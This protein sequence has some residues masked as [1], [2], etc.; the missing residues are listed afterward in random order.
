MLWIVVGAGIDVPASVPW[1]MR[2]WLSLSGLVGHEFLSWYAVLAL[3]V[4]ALWQFG[5]MR[6]RWARPFASAVLATTTIAFA[7]GG[8]HVCVPSRCEYLDVTSAHIGVDLVYGW[9][10]I[11]E[12]ARGTTVAYT[13]INLPYPLTGDRLANRVIYANIDGRPNW[14]FHDYDRAYRAGRFTPA[15]P[16][17]ATGSGELLPARDTAPGNAPARPRYERMEGFRDGW[18]NNLKSLHVGYLFIAALSAYEID[19]VWHNEHGF[20][21]EDAWAA[22]DPRSF[23]LVYENSL[24]RVFEVHLQEGTEA[25]GQW[26]GHD[27][28]RQGPPE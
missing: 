13:G 18:M 2:G 25:I 27:A 28:G 22:V 15:P 21:I 10:W 16:L 6:T 24:V 14:R 26:R 9:R 12:H 19:N 11:A 17:L 23:Q 3:L 7:V 1:F 4:A 20:P 8:E 5:P